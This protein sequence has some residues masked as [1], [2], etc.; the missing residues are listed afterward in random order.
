[1]HILYTGCAK[2]KK[3]FGANGLT[4]YM[5]ARHLLDCVLKLIGAGVNCV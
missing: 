5:T 2:L 3:K 1:M 4:G